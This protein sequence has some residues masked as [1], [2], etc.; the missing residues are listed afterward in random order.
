MKDNIVDIRDR[1][2]RHDLPCPALPCTYFEGFILGNGDLPRR[3]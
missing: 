2:A 1:V 3:D